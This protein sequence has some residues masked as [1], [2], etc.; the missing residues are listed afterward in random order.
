VRTQLDDI[1]VDRAADAW[2]RAEWEYWAAHN[3]AAQ[4]QKARQDKLGL[5]LANHDHQAYRCS[6]DHIAR[7]VGILRLLGLKLRESFYAGRQA[8]WGA[9]VMEQ[10]T[11]RFVVFADVDMSPDEEDETFALEGLEPREELGT[12]GMWTGLHG[13]SMLQAG[14]HHVALRFDFERIVTDMASRGFG[15]MAPFSDLYFLKQC[16]TRAEVWRVE[17]D[18]A[19]ALLAEG[20]LDEER[21]ERFGAEGAIGSHMELIERTE[22]FKGFNKDSVS[23]II[24]ATDPMTYSPDGRHA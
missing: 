4:V 17:K 8:G 24:A 18:R 3:G 2:F 15:S 1:S 9:Q 6:R 23:A 7:T 20:K 5:G 19:D 16:F 11:C 22:G 10:P 12:I 14:L 21:F 13:E